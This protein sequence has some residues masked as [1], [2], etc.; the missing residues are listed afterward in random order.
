MTSIHPESSLLRV[1]KAIVTQK[2]IVNGKRNDVKSFAP[3]HQVKVHRGRTAYQT[4]SFKGVPA[5]LFQGSSRFVGQIQQGSL[6]S[7][8]SATLKITVQVVGGTGTLVEVADW[9]DRIEIKSQNGSKLLTTLY[10]DTNLFNYNLIESQKLRKLKEVGLVDNDWSVI[11]TLRS[12]SDI[13]TVYL[14]LIGSVFGLSDFYFENSV[15]DLNLEFY[16]TPSGIIQSND[17]ATINCQ[18]MELICETEIL[19]PKDQETHL[20]HYSKSISS[21]RFLEPIENHF[22][23]YQMNNG[24]EY[25]LDMDAVTG[26]ISHFL[27]LIRPSGTNTQSVGGNHVYTD[28]GFD[29]TVDIQNSSGKSMFGN[30]NAVPYGF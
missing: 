8:K 9:F 24:Q 14:P 15:G 25:K 10:N 2:V 23:S 7:I 4:T 11:S 5:N 26:D 12:A 19:P 21:C 27:V 16:P 1:S 20:A 6:P 18:G 28:I 13:V 29:G 22:Y 30:G 3:L 17:N